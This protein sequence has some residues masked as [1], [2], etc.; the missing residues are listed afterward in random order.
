MP[1]PYSFAA[2]A[3]K[4]TR[5]VKI[6][7]VAHPEIPAGGQLT[8]L[9]EAAI[10]LTDRYG[11]G[12]SVRNIRR[13]IANGTWARNWHWTRTGKAIKIY[14]PAVQEY[15]DKLNQEVG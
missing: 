13:L 7:K 3:P 4:A 9:K 12:Y 5:K 8:D 11:R 10:A 1:Q 14:L 15:Q 6:A 2:A